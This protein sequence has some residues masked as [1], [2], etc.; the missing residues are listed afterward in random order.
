VRATEEDWNGLS[1]DL[2]VG[3]IE[4]GPC[5]DVRIVVEKVADRERNVVTSL[6]FDGI[7]PVPPVQSGVGCEG[8]EPAGEGDGATTTVTASTAP[9]STERTG[10]A[11]RP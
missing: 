8:A 1:V 4:P 5:G 7:T 2:R 11:D 3:V 10:T 6:R 9:I